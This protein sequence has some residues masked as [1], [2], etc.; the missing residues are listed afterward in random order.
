MGNGGKWKAQSKRQSTKLRVKVEKKVKEHARKLKKEKKKNPSKFKLKR[1]DPGIPA[2]C[3]FKEQV[4][5][6]AE[7]VVAKNVEIKEKRR[8]ELK[9]I[10]KNDKGRKLAEM[11]G[12]TLEGLA[13]HAQRRDAQFEQS[14]DIQSAALDRGLTD[15]SAKAYYKE[16]KKVIE[17]ADVILQVLDARDPLG[18]RCRE[19]EQAVAADKGGKRLV[20]VLNKADLVPRDN[21]RAWVKYL[22]HEFPTIAFKASTQSGGKLGRAKMNI[23]KT[24]GE[25]TTSRCVGADT[26]MTLLGNYCRNK[27]VKTSIRVGVVGMPNVGKSSLINSL[28][29]GK[30]CSVGATPG[31][32]KSV[33]EVSLDS[34]IKLL[35]SPGM[36]LA[37]GNMSDASVALRNAIKIET[38]VDPIT[39]VIAILSRVPRQHLMQQYTLGHYEDAAEFLA[40]LARGQG[41]LKKGGIPDRDAAAKTVLNDWNSGKI[42]YF[43]HPPE[44]VE[45]NISSEIVSEFAAEFSLDDLAAAE[46]HDMKILPAVRPSETTGLAASAIVESAS[47]EIEDEIMPDMEVGDGDDDDEVL[48]PTLVVPK[49]KKKKGKENAE[50]ELWDNHKTDPLFKLEGNL[51]MKKAEKAREKKS[52]KE[53]RRN[54]KVGMDLS[55][56]MDAA[57]GSLTTDKSEDYSFDADFK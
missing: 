45:A 26:L 29:R 35:D 31:V 50:D 17:S 16:F 38:L 25:I 49:F 1:K 39:P 15:R 9:E 47:K 24:E 56:D 57:F 30:A 54:D 41:K 11:R 8:L 6:E 4:L 5:A 19:V 2:D 42:K 44:E 22:R 33:Q 3:P 12:M 13:S 34:K 46:E 21:L 36:V 27:D 14:K 18:S 37:S 40:L 48:P 20:L 28:K 52:K 51:R 7:A 43:T 32:T 53:R 23:N 55:H 10:R